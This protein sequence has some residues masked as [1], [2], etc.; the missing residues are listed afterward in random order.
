MDLLKIKAKDIMITDPL[1]VHPTEQI[2]AVDLLMSRNHI[3][4]IP[5][6]ENGNLVGLITM[7]DIML[8]R[9]SICVNGM[10][11]EDLMRRNPASVTPESSIKEVLN[12]IVNQ[13]I[14]QIP[15]I[16]EGEVVGLI[17]NENLLK[18]LYK[19]I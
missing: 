5:V 18:M 11:V 8:S 13:Q 17:I 12:I 7:R 10:K 9:F 1:A 3:G 15:V 19:Y 16:D 14:D 6:I 2:A 4:G